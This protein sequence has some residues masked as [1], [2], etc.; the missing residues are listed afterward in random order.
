MILSVST[1][2][3]RKIDIIIYRKVLKYGKASCYWQPTYE[4]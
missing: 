2:Y 3:I 4:G 1:E